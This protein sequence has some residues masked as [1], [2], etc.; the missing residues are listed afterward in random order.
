MP[1]YAPLFLARDQR[2]DFGLRCPESRFVLAPHEIRAQDVVP[3]AHYVA[4][5]D[6]YRHHRRMRKNIAG[7]GCAE[8]FE[9]LDDRHEVV[10]VGA[11]PVQENDATRWRSRG[12]E[13]NAFE[14]GNS[15]S[16]R[17]QPRIAAL[18]RKALT[19]SAWVSI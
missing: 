11:E 18:G 15:R 19:T 17:G 16:W 12:L 14:H 3:G 1:R 9:F 5:V 13:F 6:R 2:L 10:A 7:R 4:V 8:L